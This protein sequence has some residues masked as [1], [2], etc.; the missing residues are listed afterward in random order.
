MNAPQNHHDNCHYPVLAASA[1]RSGMGKTKTRLLSQVEAE[2]SR[3]GSRKTST[4]GGA[5]QKVWCLNGVLLDFLFS[6]V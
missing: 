1:V 2:A 6:H 5:P 3:R 4:N